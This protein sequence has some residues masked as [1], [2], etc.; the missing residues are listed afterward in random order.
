M[1]VIGE[2]NGKIL[3]KAQLKNLKHFAQK[4]IIRRLH[5]ILSSS[6]NA[7]IELTYLSCTLF[8]SEWFLRVKKNDL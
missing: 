5:K 2:T 1:M 8:F 6:D 4:G 7:L 3:P